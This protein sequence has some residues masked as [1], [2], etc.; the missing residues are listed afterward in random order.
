MSSE[1]EGKPVCQAAGR[2]GVTDGDSRERPIQAGFMEGG[3]LDAGPVRAVQ[4]VGKAQL[5]VGDEEHQGFVRDLGVGEVVLDGSVRR[6][7]GLRPGRKVGAGD[8]VE[9]VA[10]VVVHAFR[11]TRNHLCNAV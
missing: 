8:D 11:V 6:L 9:P 4:Q 3:G 7:H 1:S 2:A 5:I 10:L